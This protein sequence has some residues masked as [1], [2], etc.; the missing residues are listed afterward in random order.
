[1]LR[2]I[3]ILLAVATAWGQPDLRDAYSFEPGGTP[4]ERLWQVLVV[5]GLGDKDGA[6][7]DGEVSLSSGDIHA[8]EGYRMEPPDRVLAKGGWRMST[9]A[10]RIVFATQPNAVGRIVKPMLLPKGILMRGAGEAAAVTL[11]TAQGECVFAPFQIA[12]GEARACPGGRMEVRR[13]PA[14]SDLSGTELRQHDFPS[15]AATGAGGLAAA[16]MSYHDR[17]EELNL[18]LYGE[19]R[20]SRLIPVPRAEADLWRPLATAD[21]KGR[22]WIVWSQQVKGNWDIYAMPWENNTWGRME[23]LSQDPLPDIEPHLTRGADGTVY[24]VWQAL[25][26]SVSQI[27]MRYL[28]GEEWSPVVRVTESASNNW[29]PAVTAGPDGKVWIAWDRYDSSYDIYCR[30][31][32]PSA[33]LGPEMAVAATPHK[34]AYAS[35]SV[36]RR[37]RPWVAWETGGVNW[38]KD[39][40]AA[41]KNSPGSPLGD[42]R[43]VEVAVWDSGAWKRPAALAESDPLALGASSYGRPVLFHDPNGNLWMAFHRRYSRLARGPSTMWEM[44]L[45]RL[46]AGGWTAP[47]LLPQSGARQSTR[48]GFA[49]AEGRM[50]VFW[51][52]ESRRWDFASRPRLH[53]VMMGSLPLPQAA[54]AAALAVEAP[55]QTAAPEGHSDEAGDVRAIRAY[56]A[57]AGGKALRIVRGDLHRHTEFSPDQG[58]FDDGSLP[59]FYRYMIDAANMDFGASTDHQAGGIDYWNFITQKMADMFHFPARF[60]PLFSYERNVS[61]PHGHRNIIHTTRD[62][63]IVPFFQGTNAR[64]LLP[65]APDGEILTFN[66]NSYGGVVA[67]DTKLLYEELRKSGGLSIPHTSGSPGMGTDW[68]DNDKDLE[69]VVEIYQGDRINYESPDA[70]RGPA[71]WNRNAPGGFQEAGTVWNAWKKGYKLGVISSSDHLSTHISYAMVYTP[72]QDRK[73][74][75]EAIRARHTYGATDNIVLEFRAGDRFMGDAFDTR[76]PVALRIKVR[77]TAPV[78]KVR[79]IRDAA[80]VHTFEPGKQEASLEYL[81]REKLTGE[82]WY[83]VRV[84]QADGEIA[85]SSPIWITYR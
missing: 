26:G 6:V 49:A 38:G 36:D 22:P 46:D 35:I 60:V 79:L 3:L 18:R 74:I 53:R 24:V 7:W 69:P 2:S 25:E 48:I 14:A 8:V 19:G 61:F 85:W 40:G 50:W 1:M 42:R 31:Y 11:R 52:S 66:S 41:L 47:M 5:M 51:G 21:A 9:R 63:P 77:G 37:G 17:R 45:T 70:P 64:F 59:E 16:W 80:Y 13:I 15:V 81:D 54:G 39:L 56:R 33:G 44:F 67:N 78:A 55:Q 20:W 12:I 30:S 83:Y 28:R 58:G 29:E 10:E 65:D 32:S 62:Y 82:H 57:N 4:E 72:G 43:R 73:S 27:R 34:E 68:R 76:R 23:R 71:G 84:E 75:F